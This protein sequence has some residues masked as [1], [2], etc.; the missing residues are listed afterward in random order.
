MSWSERWPRRENRG[1]TCVRAGGLRH[2]KRVQARSKIKSF[3]SRG[4]SNSKFQIPPRQARGPELGR[5]ANFKKLQSALLFGLWTLGF[6]LY[7]LPTKELPQILQTPPGIGF[8]LRYPSI[9]DLPLH[10]EGPHSRFRSRKVLL[11]IVSHHEA[12]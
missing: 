5:R 3:K 1:A 8:E 10:K 11:D 7:S 9:D 6:G 2:G 4:L 12:G